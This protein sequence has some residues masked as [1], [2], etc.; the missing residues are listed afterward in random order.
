MSALREGA[1]RPPLVTR[2]GYLERAAGS[3]GLRPVDNRGGYPTVVTTTFPNPNPVAL[4]I[5]HGLGEAPQPPP[6]LESRRGERCGGVQAES[7][8]SPAPRADS[9]AVLRRA[10]ER[11]EVQSVA[12]ER[13]LE[14]EVVG[15]GGRLSGSSASTEQSDGLDAE[16]TLD[17]AQRPADAAGELMAIL[18]AEADEDPEEGAQRAR[19]PCRWRPNLQAP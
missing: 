11:A 9:H 10:A 15:S 12:A 14:R 3:Q 13:R 1:W 8:P 18:P 4:P 7:W 2:A 5:M 16:A 6:G 17:G 19:A